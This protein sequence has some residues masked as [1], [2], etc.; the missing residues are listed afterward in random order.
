MACLPGRTLFSALLLA[1]AI[2]IPISISILMNEPTTA[3]LKAD[4]T[5]TA[6]EN[7]VE[8]NEAMRRLAQK[9]SLQNSEGWTSPSGTALDDVIS[10]VKSGIGPFGVSA[11]ALSAVMPVLLCIRFTAC[12]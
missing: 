7:R 6:E 10:I 5:K 1:L 9:A 2:W 11:L 12:A 4:P 8:F 3:F